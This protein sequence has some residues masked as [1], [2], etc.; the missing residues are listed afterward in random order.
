MSTELWMLVN[1]G[2][3]PLPY[4]LSVMLISAIGGTLTIFRK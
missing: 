4:G 3:V 2:A 1:T